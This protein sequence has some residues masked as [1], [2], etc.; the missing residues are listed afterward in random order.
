MRKPAFYICKNKDA[1]QLC[2]NCAADQ[3]LCFRYSDSTIILLP[4]LLSIFCGCTAW[5]VSDLVGN[6]EDWFS[7]DVAHNIG[8]LA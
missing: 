3:S 1:D 7:R 6:T 2:R 8:V 4:K 5:F